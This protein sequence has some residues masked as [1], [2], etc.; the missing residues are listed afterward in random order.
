[1]E[2]LNLDP[3]VGKFVK[4]VFT[5]SPGSPVEIRK[6][7]LIAYDAEF[8]Q[9]KSLENVHLINRWHVISLKASDKARGGE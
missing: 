3:L 4:V 1:M 9:L 6:G 5:E 2:A 7:Q 8:L